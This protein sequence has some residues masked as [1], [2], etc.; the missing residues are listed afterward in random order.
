MHQVLA[1]RAKEERLGAV[2]TGVLWIKKKADTKCISSTS[3][4][5]QSG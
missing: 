4:A 5:A 1:A 3:N 2:A